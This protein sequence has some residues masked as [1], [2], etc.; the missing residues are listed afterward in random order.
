V[1]LCGKELYLTEKLG[2]LS[3]TAQPIG[4]QVYLADASQTGFARESP[5]F[6]NLT[7]RITMYSSF[8]KK[9]AF[10]GTILYILINMG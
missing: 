6:Q 2:R 3:I 8:R 7:A 9:S 5:L 10:W 1:Q 4:R